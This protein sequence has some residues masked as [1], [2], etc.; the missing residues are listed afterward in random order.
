MPKPRRKSG[1]TKRTAV[2]ADAIVRDAPTPPHGDPFEGMI[3]R[4]TAGA[5]RPAGSPAKQGRDLA[6]RAAQARWRKKTGKSSAP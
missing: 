3:T 4:G 5:T 1:Q 2:E 6:M